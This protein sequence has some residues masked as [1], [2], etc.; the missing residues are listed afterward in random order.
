MEKK[1][2]SIVSEYDK[3][4]LRGTVY[5]PNGEKKGI[6][7]IEHGM[8]EYKKRYEEM[9]NFFCS[10]GYVVV[11]CDHRGHGDSVE[12]AEDRGWFRDKTGQAFVDD[13]VQVTKYIKSV[14]PDL[15]L[16]LFGHRM[17]SMIVRC[18]IQK[19][20][21]LIDKLIVCGSPANNPLAGVG[22]FVAKT[23]G[24]FKG[25]RHRSKLLAYLSTGKGN[26]NFPGEGHGSWL[27]RNRENIEKFYSDEKCGYIFTCNGFE[28]LFKLMKS[29]YRKKA[30]EVKNPQL[31][32]LFV[33][34]SDDAVLGG[35]KN[36]K[37]T[38]DMMSSVGYTN[39]SS[40]LYKGLRHEIFND[41][42]KE[43]VYADLLEFVAL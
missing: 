5:E 36:F 12:K 21:E 33:S 41:L 17:G 18:Y 3:L 35:E 37:K 38:V 13:S 25:E 31:P 2:F 26:D 23:I 16:I 32:I 6:I 39:V 4:T 1:E 43:E 14:Y 27:S 11:C 34:G 24:L 9:M 29:T 7:Q 22:V 40:K 15:P 8:C 30:Y 20:E 28:N 10:Y 42:G 19:H